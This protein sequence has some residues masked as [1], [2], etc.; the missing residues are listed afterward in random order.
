MPDSDASP[1][2]ALRARLAQLEA[3]NARLAR[4]LAEA[5]A[6]DD[7]ARRDNEAWLRLAQE[8]GGICSWQWDVATDS[9]TWSDSCHGLHGMD[10]ASP[11]TF[12]AWASGIHPQDRPAVDAD[13]RE[14]MEG[15]ADHW[16]NEF[17]Y[18]RHDDG[19]VRWLV[20]RGRIVRDAVTGAPS[21][22]IGI[23]FDITDRRAAEEQQ[24]LLMRELDHRARNLLAVVQAALRLTPKDDAEQYARAVEGRIAALAR[25]QSILAEARWVGSDLRRI[26]EGELAPFRGTQRVVL[27]GPPVSLPARS[28]QALAMAM[29]EMATNAVKHGALS[30]RGGTVA[31]AWQVEAPGGPP[32]LALRW[33]ESGGPAVLPPRRK[34]FGSRVLEATLREQ[35]GGE[36]D[37]DW[38]PGGLRCTLRLPLGG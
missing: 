2:A 16:G 18:I 1:E 34:G 15:G 25:T 26:L 14:A 29:H 36:I 31:V 11:P 10:P 8:A 28:C 32:A 37:L 35:L 5:G 6:Q 7:A 38:A 27:D 3:E 22:L 13:L 4:A 30:S 12:A 19:A 21:R 17:R 24:A 20:G 23:G 33:T 9:L